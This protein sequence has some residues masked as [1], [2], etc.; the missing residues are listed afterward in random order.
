MENAKL[1]N[2]VEM[3]VIFKRLI[4]TLIFSN[5]MLLLLGLISIPLVGNVATRVIYPNYFICY[6]FLLPFSYAYISRRLS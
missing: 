6:L 4:A 2:K 1:K 5:A 3:M